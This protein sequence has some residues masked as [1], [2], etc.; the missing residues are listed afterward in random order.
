MIEVPIRVIR[1]AYG[2]MHST[3]IIG[4]R[5]DDSMVGAN[6]LARNVAVRVVADGEVAAGW[7]LDDLRSSVGFIDVKYGA[8]VRSG[9]RFLD[10]AK[11]GFVFTFAWV[12]VTVRMVEVSDSAATMTNHVLFGIAGSLLGSMLWRLGS[13]IAA[14]DCA[15]WRFR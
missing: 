12:S 8:N 6:P 13:R 1:R 3:G 14:E 2:A 15:P 4:A 11:F 9:P 5:T 7:A 10:M